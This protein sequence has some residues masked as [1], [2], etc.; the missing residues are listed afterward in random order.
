MRQLQAEIE[1]VQDLQWP[2]GLMA[3]ILFKWKNEMP[4]YPNPLRLYQTMPVPKFMLLAKS[5]QLK[6]YIRPMPLDYMY[7]SESYSCTH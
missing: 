2:F 3:A 1:S 6:H 4:P 5:G 7:N